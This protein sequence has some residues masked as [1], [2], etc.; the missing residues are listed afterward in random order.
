MKLKKIINNEID[1]DYF[2]KKRG[3]DGKIIP[4][5]KGNQL[6]CVNY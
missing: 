3:Q 1:I 6:E 2:S 4:L 5:Y